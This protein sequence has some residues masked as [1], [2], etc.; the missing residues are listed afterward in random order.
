M[1]VRAF[2]WSAWDTFNLTTPP[3][4]PPV[5]TI[6]D[7]SLQ[8]N[9]WSKVA[10]WISYSDI[11]GNAATLYQFRDSGAGANSGYFW[12]PDNAHQPANTDITVMAGDL[13]NVWVRGGMIAGSDH[14]GARLRLE[15]LGY[16]QSHHAAEHASGRNDRRSQPANQRMVEGCKLDFLLRHRGQRGDPVSVPGQRRRREQRL[17]LDA[18]QRASTGEHGHHRH[19]RRSRQCVGAWRHGRR[20]G[21]HVGTR[22]RRHGL[23]RLGYVQSHDAADQPRTDCDCS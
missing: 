1:S 5:A 4:T 6:D 23:E 13:G 7:H 19:G 18:R 2:D 20:L 22:L 10:S 8:I 15:R 9:E 16:V 11:E 17:L 3:N 12:T 21:D 14:V